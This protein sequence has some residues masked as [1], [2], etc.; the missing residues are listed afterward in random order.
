MLTQARLKELLDYD[1]ETGIFT[2]K[3]GH[4]YGGVRKAGGAAGTYLLR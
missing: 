1:P 4:Q 2:W 3:N